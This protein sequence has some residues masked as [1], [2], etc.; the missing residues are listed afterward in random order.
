MQSKPSRA[1]WVVFALAAAGSFIT[2]LDL[3]IV[4][5]AFAEISKT[6]SGAS[7]ADIAW[8]VTIYNIMFA[9]LLVAGGKTA[10]RVGRKR[11]FLWGA[12]IFGIGS[13][14]CALSP[15]L[16]VL[17]LGRALQ[18]IG[19]ALLTPAAL[20]ILLAAFPA[21]RRTQVVS[22]SGA[23]GALGV[24]SGPTLGAL[25]ISAFGWRAAF[26]INVPVVLG[27]LVVGVRVLIDSEPESSAVR[28][29]YL[30][31]TMITVGLGAIALAISQ[32]EAWGLRDERVIVS[33]IVFAVIVPLF[34]RR[35][36]RHPEPIVDLQLFRERHFALANM[37]TLLF[38]IGF[39]SM[40]L[41]NVL[42]LRTVWNYSVLQAGMASCLAP[43][44]VALVSTRSAKLAGRVG[45]R[46]LLVGG[47]ILFLAAAACDIAFLSSTPTI[48]RWLAIGFL[49]GCAIGCTLP[50]LSSA[51]VS[52]LA[53]N[54][55]AVG[56]AINSTARQI[57]AVL[58]VAMLVAIQGAGRATIAGFDRGWTLAIFA[59][60]ASS[61]LSSLQP[62][63]TRTATT[64]ASSVGTS[65]AL[66]AE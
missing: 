17:I 49:Q 14:V 47:P 61:V 58:G 19:G 42:F 4:N 63:G 25:L 40:L 52:S 50:I 32:S 12:G 57:G 53:P 28:P 26:W 56:G 9:S 30:G 29:D 2:T 31:A 6:Y 55:F 18:G 5:V 21:E 16:I 11:V 22:L 38:M 51:A 39:S 65:V 59:A 1:A 13:V 64:A 44:T 43:I 60:L 23:V 41:N 46:P 54:R 20:G 36:R 66:A 35:Q 45:F 62:A 33:I 27:V 7:T 8:I 15:S 37:A 24:A 3:S 48:G 10:D 34:V